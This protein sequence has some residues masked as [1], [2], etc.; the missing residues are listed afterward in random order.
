M[1]AAAAVRLRR[2]VQR[3]LRGLQRGAFGLVR[4]RRNRIGSVALF[5]VAFG[6]APD[7]SEAAILK[8]L[9]TDG[10]VD[11]P[12]DARRVLMRFDQ[13][14]TPTPFR[15]R[16]TDRDLEKLRLDGFSLYVDHADASVSAVIMATGTWEP[17]VT[18]QLRRLL[19]PGMT[20]VDV[21]ASV[22]FH[23]FLS[24][25]LVGPTGRVIALEASSENCR[26]LLLN[27]LLNAADQVQ[28]LPVALDCSPGLVHLGA[29]IGVNANLIASDEALLASGR[30]EMVYATRLDDTVSDP[31]H[32]MKIDVEGAEHRVL[33]G[34][35]QT[36]LRNRPTIIMEFSCEMTERVS[37]VEPSAPLD[38]LFDRGYH[39][40]VIDKA[41]GDLVEY[42]SSQALLDA[43][44]DYLRIEDLLWLPD[45]ANV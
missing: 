24:A 36:I 37:G 30:G 13:R 4:R 1:A 31:V 40:H 15:V 27:R 12:Q 25:A 18:K 42:P 2:H 38:W 14:T 45:D 16:F 6:R 28:I 5:R 17:H 10:F 32:V 11:S 43:W 23:T 7:R 33:V 8:G 3:A 34:A 29:G 26:L 19:A 44:G 35:A 20:M 39:L 41:H 21:G 9:S 22:G